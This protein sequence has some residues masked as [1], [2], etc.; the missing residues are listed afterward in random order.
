MSIEINILLIFMHRQIINYETKR[1]LRNEQRYY[2]YLLNLVKLNNYLDK[3]LYD[4]CA[5]L[6]YK[7]SHINLSELINL[8][9]I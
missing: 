8:R 1:S 6:F 4:D 5:A 3:I 2:Y 9:K 7:L